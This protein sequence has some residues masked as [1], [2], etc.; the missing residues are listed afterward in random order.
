MTTGFVER[1]K[2]RVLSSA[3]CVTQVGKGGPLFKGSG[4]IYANTSTAG[5]GNTSDTTSDTLDSFSLPA[6]SLQNNNYLLNIFAFGKLGAGHLGSGG[7]QRY[8]QG[9]D[10]QRRWRDRHRGHRHLD[11]WSDQRRDGERHRAER[12]VHRGL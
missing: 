7:C 1:I 4:T 9:G 8:L 6:N 3:D 11:G 5:F 12:V 2:G 10:V